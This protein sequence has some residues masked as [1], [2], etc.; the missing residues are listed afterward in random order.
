QR[1]PPTQ[2]LLQPQLL[3]LALLQQQQPQLLALAL[4][5]QQ[6]PQQHQQQQP[7]Q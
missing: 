1:L 6:Q 5:Q 4:L 3:A 7:Q 2:L